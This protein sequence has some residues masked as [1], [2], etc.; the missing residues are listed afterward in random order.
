VPHPALQSFRED[1]GA[2]AEGNR[3]GQ[4]RA[5]EWLMLKHFVFAREDEPGQAWLSRFAAGRQESEQWYLGTR[6][7]GVPSGTEC[8][9]ALL[10]HMPELVP[11]YDWVC[12]L[13][14]DDERAQQILSHYRP[15]PEFSACS[16]AV[17]F[18]DG[19]PALVRNYDF[20]LDVVSAR[21]ELTSWAGGKVIA[22]AQRPWGGCLDG[23]NQDGLVT[24][25]TFGGS[26]ATGGGFSVILMQRYIL[27]TCRDVKEAIAALIRIPIAQSQNITLLDRSGAHATL[28]L[29]PE[30]APAVTTARVCTNH[31]ESVV[32][33]AHAASSQTRA[34]YDTLACRLA[35]PNMT[36]QRLVEYL[37]LPPLYS[38]RAAS[39]T[40]Y[41]AL[42]RPAQGE[43]DYLW[44]GK[45][46]HQS[47]DRF[48]P[49]EYTHDYGGL[50]L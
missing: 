39:P 24:S 19:G 43:V 30:R 27:E 9:S 49:G 2:P 33:P 28:F 10:S 11:H 26:P 14:G 38:R 15:P 34:R 7:T 8:R 37:L 22:K 13:V 31:Q 48:V 29:G 5:V 16:Q 21:F 45:R 12:A 47:L 18:G 35:E 6:G 44:P 4:K 42:Y 25:C 20:A 50:I 46:W 36:L 41:T 40:V 17:W 3:R 32:W 1:T 23:M